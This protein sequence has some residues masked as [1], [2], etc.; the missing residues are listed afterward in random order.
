[1]SAL[2]LKADKAQTCCHVRLVPKADERA[3]AKAPLF[4][5]LVGA[6]DERRWDFEAERPRSLEVDGQVELGRTFN[7]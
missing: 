5:H 4:D 1:M 3:A 2:P 6:G 7:W